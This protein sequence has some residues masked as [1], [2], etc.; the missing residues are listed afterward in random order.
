LVKILVSV[1]GVIFHNF[2]ELKLS[3]ATRFHT[4][5]NKKI[6]IFSVLLEKV[7]QKLLEKNIF[8]VEYHETKAQSQ[9]NSFIVYHSRNI[10]KKS[11]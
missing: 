8:I 5:F 9:K 6:L 2:D 1:F 3:N 10:G 11:K 4:D 7:A